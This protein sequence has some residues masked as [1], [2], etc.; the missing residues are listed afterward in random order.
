VRHILAGVACI[1]LGWFGVMQGLHVPILSDA[2][3]GFHQL[4]HLVTWFL[5]EVYRLMMGSLFQVLLPLGFAGY[6]LLFHRDLVGVV[7]MLGWTGLAAGETA[8]YIADAAAP[9]MVIGPGHVEHDWAI[10]LT[11]LDR[12]AA[13]DELAWIVQ[14]AALVCIFV[15][16]GV[17]AIGAVRAV[18]EKQTASRVDIYLERKPAQERGG[19]DDWARAQSGSQAPPPSAG[20]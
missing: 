18:M 6:F 8:A 19:Y 2:S 4:G 1:L 17:A 5:P 12:M 10:A 11:T 13:V 16:M 9:T 15:G 14:A 3:Y 20:S 7:I